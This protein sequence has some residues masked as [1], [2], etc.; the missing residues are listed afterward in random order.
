MEVRGNLTKGKKEDRKNPSRRGLDHYL[1]KVT[2]AW[3]KEGEERREPGGEKKD[4]KKREDQPSRFCGS[5]ERKEDMKRA[6]PY[7]RMGGGGKGTMVPMSGPKKRRKR[8]RG[9]Q[10]LI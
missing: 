4:F 7:K 2:R 10:N 5:L 9:E 1:L 6:G 8:G 3:E